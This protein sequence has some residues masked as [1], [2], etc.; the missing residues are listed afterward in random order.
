MAWWCT[1]LP[2]NRP[3]GAKVGFHLG[4]PSAT[5]MC[6][7]HPY[8]QRNLLLL[9][10]SMTH[11]S[12]VTVIQQH[13]G[14]NCSFLHLLVRATFYLV[15]TSWWK[16]CLYSLKHGFASRLTGCVDCWYRLVRI[17]QKRL[18][19]L[20]M[21]NSLHYKY[22]CLSPQNG[23]CLIQ[24]MW[25]LLAQGGYGWRSPTAGLILRSHS[26]A[27]ANMILHQGPAAH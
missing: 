15:I 10:D 20:N 22:S 8:T 5:L 25:S 26:S 21:Q 13:V 7:C 12:P 1:W 17:S 4:A 9:H 16:T 6:A 24:Q 3:R 14:T 23:V 2:G 11:L 27:G 18:E 19:M